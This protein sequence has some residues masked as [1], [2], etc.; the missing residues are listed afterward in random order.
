MSYLYLSNIVGST[1]GTALVGFVLMEFLSMRQISLILLALGVVLGALLYMRTVRGRLRAGLI[2]A[3]AGVVAASALASGPLF[4]TIY[5]RM[6][7]KNQ[8]R[9]GY[10][11][12]HLV[13][14][15]GGVIAVTKDGVVF[16]GGVYDGRF[17]TSLV[18]DTNMLVRAYAVAAFHPAPK[19][20]LMVGLSSGSWAQVIVNDPAV[21]QLTAVEINPAYLKL[22]AEHPDVASALRNPKLSIVIDD[23][24]RWLV[25]HPDRQFDAIVMNTTYHWRAHL[26]NLLSTE[27]LQLA[28]RHL[29]PGG[30]LYYNTTGSQEVLKTG[31]TEFRYGMRFLNFLALSDRPLAMDGDSWRARLLAWRIDGKPVLDL[32]KP[33]DRERLEKTLANASPSAVGNSDAFPVEYEASIRQRSREKRIITDDNMG[34]EWR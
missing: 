13:E 4:D 32:S 27:F 16:G 10:R 25:R 26:T 33:L 3:A 12:A 20:V 6:L 30:V 23:G 1:V 28:R 24:R 5:E 34:T 2:A 29:R 18:H 15:R 9:D 8:Y 14:S 19:R 31:V 7:W 17:N 11:F 22:I 21:E